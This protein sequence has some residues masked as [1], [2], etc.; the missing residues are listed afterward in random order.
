MEGFAGRMIKSNCS[1]DYIECSSADNITRGVMDALFE[2]FIKCG[3]QCIV[4]RM[5]RSMASMLSC[6]EGAWI[7]AMCFIEYMSSLPCSRDRV[8]V[9]WENMNSKAST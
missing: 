2:V 4:C 3:C 5:Y 7:N 6:R 8:V 9:E 1:V